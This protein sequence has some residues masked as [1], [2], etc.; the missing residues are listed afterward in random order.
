MQQCSVLNVVYNL[1]NDWLGNTDNLIINVTSIEII[2]SI[3]KTSTF[4]VDD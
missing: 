2:T 4:K 3:K 1:V